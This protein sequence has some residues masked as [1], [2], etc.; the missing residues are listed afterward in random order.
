MYRPELGYDY[1]RNNGRGLFRRKPA[2][3]PNLARQVNPTNRHTGNDLAVTSS[4]FGALAA[5]GN[6]HQRRALAAWPGRRRACARRHGLC[7][8]CLPLGQVGGDYR[9]YVWSSRLSAA[10]RLQEL[11]QPRLSSY[12]AGRP[13]A[14][15]RKSWRCAGG[16]D[17]VGIRDQCARVRA[18]WQG[19]RGNA[20]SHARWAL[21]AAELPHDFMLLPSHGPL[22][23]SQIH[24]RYVSNG[25]VTPVRLIELQTYLQLILL[26]T[27]AFLD[28][29]TWTR[30]RDLRINGLS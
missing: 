20:G 28:S 22:C 24:W 6:P 16:A 21:A 18:A 26:P 2:V 29:P 7:L 3:A 11:R 25:S 12:P 19:A 17:R 10:E 27:F 8:R 15:R 9:R 4:G 5:G 13:A 1:V 30:T 14:A 23:G